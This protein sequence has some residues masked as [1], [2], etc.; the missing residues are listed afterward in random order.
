MADAVFEGL[1]AGEMDRIAGKG[2][3]RRY[4]AG[5]L[6]FA[7]GDDAEHIYFIRSGTVTVFLG[8][9][10]NQEELGTLGP[11]EYFGEMAFFGKNKRSAS[12]TAGTE[13][14]VLGLDKK[15]FFDLLREDQSLAYKINNI[16]SRRYQELI[17][18]ECV[19]AD[20]G[21]SGDRLHI[22]IKGDA[23]LK[24]TAFT[25]ERFESIVDTVLPELVPRIE[26]V[27][28]NRCIYQVYL[29]FNNGEVRTASVF[30]PFREDVHPAGK[31]VDESYIDR[32]FPRVPFD[33]KASFIRTLYGTITDSPLFSS[34]PPEIQGVFRG[35][36]VSWRPVSPSDISETLAKLSVLREIPYFY[37]RNFT[38]SM[39]R[40]AVR[41]QFNCDG[42][43]I[44][45][46]GE[47]QR[48]ID[49]TV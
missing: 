2:F 6:I 4:G 33:E 15:S 1:T 32:H 35:H 48:F 28:L 5:E 42:T 49:E 23:S 9:F 16:L 24:N 29:G 7:Q 13:T 41:L 38:I 31:F 8:K 27:L 3:V 25:R 20:T 11:G 36:A 44:V 10:E 43:H 12:V 47:Y 40:D 46:A 14:E 45:S 30:D 19:L 18:K 37:I 17:L 21:L 34:L 39:A 26:D 22:S